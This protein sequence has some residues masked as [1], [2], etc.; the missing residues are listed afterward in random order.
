MITDPEKAK[1]IGFPIY[2]Q[3][4][5]NREE[6]EKLV[7]KLYQDGKT[8]REIA[9]QAH[10]S[11][12]SI[13]TIIRRL[14]DIENNDTISSDMN[15]KSKTTQ[16]LSLFSQGKRPIEVAIKLDL[17]ASEIEDILQEYWVLN[18]LDEL[19]LIY[20]EIKNH[21]DPFLRL[22]HIMKNNKLINEKD[23]KTVLKYATDL[24]SLEN[25]FRD[26]ANIVL[27]L[28][29]KKKELKNTIMQQNTQL[30]DL[31][32]VINQYQNTIDSKKHQLMKMDTIS[33]SS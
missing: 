19:A 30:F 5:L 33:C 9:K 23:I 15:N 14:N 32:Q 3:I 12:G 17:Q 16:A 22:F 27:D 31:G 29:I 20:L 18:E 8:I 11:F 6:K 13:G 24:P 1:S 26:L 28:E 4:M 21:L 7:V 10:L 2:N 25:K